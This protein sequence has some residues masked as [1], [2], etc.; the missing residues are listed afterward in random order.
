MEYEKK[1][2][3][4]SSFRQIFMFDEIKL[5]MLFSSLHIEVTALSLRLSFKGLVT[6]N[7]VLKDN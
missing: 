7:K 4:S 2:L 3:K 5:L 6:P 1:A